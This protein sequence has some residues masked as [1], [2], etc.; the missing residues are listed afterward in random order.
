VYLGA[1]KLSSL[2][3]GLNVTEGDSS[4]RNKIHIGKFELVS[5][6]DLTDEQRAARQRELA[7]F[8]RDQKE[9]AAELEESGEDKFADCINAQAS[10]A[11]SA[12]A[13]GS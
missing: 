7:E 10:A 11:E 4:I 9:F 8:S 12:L 3:S 6:D 2:D 1:G 13:G 5:Y